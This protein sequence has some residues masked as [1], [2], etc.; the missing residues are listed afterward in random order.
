MPR[1]RRSPEQARREIMEA[2]KTVLITQGP[3]ALKISNIAKQAGISHPL[4]LHHFGS[5]D[6]LILN[7]QNKIAR[8]IRE[9]LLHTFQNIS[10][11][12]G[13]TQALGDLSS[14]TNARLM[15]WLIAR[16]HSPFPPEEEKGLQQ[17]RDVLHHKTGRPKKELNNLI[18]IILFAMYGEGLFGEALRTR[19][20]IEDPDT[21][22]QDFQKWLLQKVTKP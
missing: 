14:P 8:D 18:L 13:I 6:G 15:A 1:K 12:K 4:I 5:T 2:A 7:L 22:Q 9:Q 16:G 19:L 11:E 10:I 17:I 20:G 3:D 21:A